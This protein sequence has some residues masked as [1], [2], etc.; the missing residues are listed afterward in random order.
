MSHVGNAVK[1][2][3]KILPLLVC[4]DLAGKLGEALEL[5]GIVWFGWGFARHG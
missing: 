5:L 1:D 2:A 3:I 4:A